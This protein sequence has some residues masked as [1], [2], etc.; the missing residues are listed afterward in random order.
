MWP[1]L[2]IIVMFTGFCCLAP[3]SQVDAAVVGNFTEVEGRVDLLR[4]GKLPAVAAKV[5]DG[6]EA[7]D[8]VRTKSA[9]RAQLKFVD[10]TT[11]NIAPSSRVAI[12]EYMYDAAKGQRRAVMQVFMGLVETTVTKIF[13]GKEPDFHLKTH[14]AIMGVR[15]T[16]WYAR[17]LPKAT[18]VYTENSLLSVRNIFPEVA[19]EVLLKKLQYTLVG[20]NLPP[21]VPMDI[22]P[23]DLKLIQNLFR[24]Q[25]QVSG[26][27]G[28]GGPSQ[29]SPTGA[30]MGA[31]KTTTVSQIT[32]LTQQT[33]QSNLV[34]N[35]TSAIYVPPTITP[36]VS[37]TT[38][39]SSVLAPFFIQM[40][41]GSGAGDLDLHLTGPQSS[42]FHVYFGQMGSLTSQP[43]A[44]LHN[45]WLH[46]SGSEVITVSQFNL[47]DVYR[48]SVYNYSNPSP[49]STQL[50]TSSGV[51]LQVI[52]GGTVV[53][54]SGGLN[55]KAVQGGTTVMTVTP[56]TAQAGNT[57]QAVE[58]NPTNG[59]INPV[60]K[61]VNSANSASVQ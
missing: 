10:D 18:E 53:D 33:T 41:W 5:Q 34:L 15:G 1:H 28:A 60:N 44:L 6:V 50:A 38:T 37:S 14:T 49:T 54:A 47:G 32:A 36:I 27:G 57:W 39:T 43:Y 31:G 21:T 13:P 4:G 29:P 25:Q 7:G 51:S 9:S 20:A 46:P 56:T 42:R 35:P 55:G 11:M 19:G 40:Q 2:L 17:L 59:Q 61:I 24:I 8:V 45:D 23:D 26:A 16:K 3:T 48:A 12:E 30:T 58:I 22:T 52:K